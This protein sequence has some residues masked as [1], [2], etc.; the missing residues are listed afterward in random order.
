MGWYQWE[1]YV[2]V[3]VRRQRAFKKMQKLLKKG[4]NI[5]PVEIEGRKIARTFWG[6]AWCDHL[7]SF[8]DY[9]NR[10]PRGRTYVRNG[11]VC[12]LDIAKGEIEAMVSGSE[13]YKVKI[14]IKTLPKKKWTDVKT[15]CAGQVGSLLELLQGRLSQ[16]VMSVV[17]D[18]NK[19]LFPR[20]GEISLKCNCP[21]WAVM[22][23][24][25]AAVLYG[26][27]ARLDEKPELLFLLR[28]VDH[29][30]L[31]STEADMVATATAGAKSGRRRIADDDLADVFGIEM[32][33]TASPARAKR[34]RSREKVDGSKRKK[35][36]K[37]SVKRVVKKKTKAIK[38]TTRVKKPSTSK[39]APDK[40]TSPAAPSVRTVIGKDVAK[41][42]AKFDMSKVQFAKLLGV[43]APSI[44]NWEKKARTLNLQPRTLKIWNS[45]KGIT[46]RQAINRLNDL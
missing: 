11:S 30:E 43:S 19:G 38:K 46:K 2:P 16:G 31:I 25:V 24:H 44:N 37:T 21:D 29:E 32:S 42:R 5:Q 14:T 34:S 35:V 23:K 28:G 15:R 40:K 22:C 45:V 20:P 26:V 39:K 4:M 9:E 7:E 8:S 17:T 1:P 18:R 27:G 33:K 41:L 10:L 6:E 12:H 13:L 36:S 3:A